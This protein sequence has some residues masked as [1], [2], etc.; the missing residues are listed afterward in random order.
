MSKLRVAVDLDDT[1]AQT[2]KRMV[3]LINN[4]FGTSVKLEDFTEW[5]WWKNVEPFKH[6]HDTLGPE[7]A[8]NLVW[9]LYAIGWWNPRKITI[10]P[11]AD[12]VMDELDQDARFVLDV[13][14]QRQ[15]NSVRDAVQWLHS[16]LIP[17]RAFTALDALDTVNPSTKADLDYDIYIDDSPSLA[18]KL[19]G[20]KKEMILID[21]PW[22]RHV[23]ER[24]TLRRV[25]GWSDVPE[26]LNQAWHR[27][28]WTPY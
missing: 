28:T 27:L 9:R 24:N 6:I 20:T 1:L 14:S 8:K 26:A 15:I 23:P 10:M 22:N 16:K 5:E 17:F 11:E 12:V 13:V 21:R 3:E 4:D 19:L 7:A 2:N 18:V 25:T